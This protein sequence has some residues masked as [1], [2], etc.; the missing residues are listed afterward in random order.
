MK[1]EISTDNMDEAYKWYANHD[2]EILGKT[3]IQ[4]MFTPLGI[5]YGASV[6]CS[7]GKRLNLTE[8]DKW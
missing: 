2:C 3:H 5:G 6:K 1:F 4:F 7:C 8:Y